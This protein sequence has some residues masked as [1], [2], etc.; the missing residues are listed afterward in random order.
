VFILGLTG[1]IGMGKSTIAAMFRRRGVPVYDADAAVHAL[2]KPG[3]PALGLIEARFPGVVSAAGLDRGK[4]G[5]IVF[6]DRQA[7]ADLNA[8]MH[9]LVRRQQCTWLRAQALRRRALVVL[10]IPLLFE[11]GGDKRCD[12]TV[13]VSAPPH[14][15]RAR[16]MARPG[17]T[18]ETFEHILK[19][20]TP[21]S[22]KRRKAAFIVP[23]GRGK[24]AS[25]IAVRKVIRQLKG[26]NPSAWRPGGG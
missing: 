23:T 5:R 25:A 2:Q 1:S 7:L 18:E 8:I 20:Q 3:A 6:A 16:V 26:M 14:I 17:M 22:Q 19:R 15:Q 9:P 21:D 11:T 13:V 24:R 4:L 12:A 10:D